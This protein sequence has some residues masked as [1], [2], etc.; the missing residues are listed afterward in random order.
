MFVKR[1]SSASLGSRQRFFYDLL[2]QLP[3]IECAA[4]NLSDHVVRNELV[5]HDAA[6]L[7]QSLNAITG[8]RDPL[9]QRPRRLSLGAH[10]RSK[11]DA[12]PA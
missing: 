2:P 10:N 8:R 11:A 9:G 12:A 7:S 1:R 6:L 3:I 5:S 4:V